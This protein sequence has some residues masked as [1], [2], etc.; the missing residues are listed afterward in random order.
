MYTEEKYS[1]KAFAF[2]V[3]S[4][5]GVPRWVRGKWWWWSFRPDSRVPLEEAGAALD[6]LQHGVRLELKAVEGGSGAEGADS[7]CVS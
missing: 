5:M 2:S 1:E 4:V 3:G 7:L 6:E